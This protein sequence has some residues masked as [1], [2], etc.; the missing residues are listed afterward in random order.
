MELFSKRDSD[1][2]QNPAG[3]IG[4]FFTKFGNNLLGEIHAPC[5]LFGNFF[6]LAVMTPWLIL[7]LVAS[8]AAGPP[9]WMSIPDVLQ[10]PPLDAVE[11][12]AEMISGPSF[13]RG[14]VESSPMKDSSV[15]H[16]EYGSERFPLRDAVEA[17][18]SSTSQIVSQSLRDLSQSV[19][20]L[21]SLS[22]WFFHL[23]IIDAHLVPTL[24]S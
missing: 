6:F 24:I 8:T 23:Q 10:P 9:Y 7:F 16:A 1:K 15:T 17:L 21:S 5:S 22:R 12:G 18:P 19:S 4:N 3:I 13:Q 2:L 11:R 20:S 14:A